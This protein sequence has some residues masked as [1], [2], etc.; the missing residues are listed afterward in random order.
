MVL[1]AIDGLTVGT[2]ALF[3]AFVSN[4]C[5]VYFGFIL[6]ET[7]IVTIIARFVL[8]ESPLYLSEKGLTGTLNQVISKIAKFNKSG[9]RRIQVL[10][11]PS[12]NNESG[13]SIL[14]HLR[15]RGWRNVVSLL[16]QWSITS[17]NYFLLNLYL[18]SLGGKFMEHAVN[19][20]LAESVG[21]LLG[22]VL[23]MRER[24]FQGKKIRFTLILTNLLPAVG[25]IGLLLTQ[26]GVDS[27]SLMPLF[28]S[29]VSVGIGSAYVLQASLVIKLVRGLHL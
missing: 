8:Q 29:L 17:F 4:R 14:E 15:Q 13:T 2:Q 23:L 24:A 20:S 26:G 18:E 25:G 9:V 12:E 7:V 3:Y 10:E 16:V 1:M 6:L 27:S 11:P 5:R 21:C 19:S 22:G 28:V